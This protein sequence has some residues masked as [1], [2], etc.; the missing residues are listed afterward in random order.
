MP[1]VLN[2]D[3]SERRRQQSFYRPELD[4]L[5]FFAFFAVFLFHTVSFPA[6]YFV[7]HHIPRIL[8]DSWTGVASGGRY[9]VNLFFV[10][11]SYLITELLLREKEQH[12]SLDI[13]L[14]YLRRILRIWPLYYF[15]VLLTVSFAL[16]D[17]ARAF[18]LRY[19]LPF[20]LLSGNWAFLAFGYPDHVAATPLWSVSVE[21]QF[22]L[23]WPPLVAKL[24]RRQILY[25]A[26][27][28][29]VVANLT[30]VAMLLS[31]GISSSLWF[32]TFADLDSIGAGILLAITLC[33]ST[34]SI[35]V[36]ART[37]M[38][39]L[40]AC[41]IA[42][43]GYFQTIT[44]ESLTWGNTIIGWPAVVASCTAILIAFI[45][46]PVQLPWLTYLGKISYGLYAY[47]I[48]CIM[49]VDRLLG[50]QHH[51][52]EHSF[53]HIA[54]RE[55]LSLGLTIV[56]SAASYALLE[57]PFLRLKERFTRVRSRPV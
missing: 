40:G 44:G 32:N 16:F 50:M 37:T 56:V 13:R 28:M 55:S 54:L 39:L 42:L 53:A 47:H 4:A 20:F 8:G 43:R 18:G 21:E 38:L 34:P 1:T 17:P 10:L 41:C 36:A 33:G 48:I 22:Y 26:W 31:H 23:I 29:I 46:L 15:V 14:F 45:G 12:G 25:S 27:G 5:R 9:G 57:R 52:S 11:S 6:D 24:S 30:R 49:L 3:S 19:V 7:Q 2:Q 51:V 35:G